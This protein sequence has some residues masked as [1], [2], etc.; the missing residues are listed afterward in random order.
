LIADTTSFRA[1]ARRRSTAWLAALALFLSS[2][3]AWANVGDDAWNRWLFDPDIVVAAILICLVYSAG[4]VRRHAIDQWRFGRHGA[5]FTGAVAVFLALESPIDVLA[6]HLFWI[7]QV[8]HMLLCMIGP[9]LLAFS[10]PQ[11]TLLSGLPSRLRRG[12]LIVADNNM[13]RWAFSFLMNATVVTALFI[14]ALCVWQYPPYHNAAML[15]DSIHIAMHATMFAAGLLFWWRVFD[16]R[17]AATGLSYVARL[18]MLW[19]VALSQMGLG[20]Y[21]M[22]KSEVLYPSYDVIGRLFGMKPLTDELIGG[23][24]IWVPG[25]M[26]CLLAAIAVIHLWGDYEMRADGKPLARSEPNSAAMRYPTMAPEPVVQ[27]RPKNR[28]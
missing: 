23:F 16:M 21:I 1:T 3:A 25:S 28:L 26:L 15:N 8:N 17:P 6:Q 10:A 4:L 9:M 12:A 20:A 19:I 18:M 14:A 24:V 13:L 27:A 22:L 5:F 11:A 2:T 7:H